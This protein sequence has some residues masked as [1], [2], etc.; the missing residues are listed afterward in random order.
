MSSTDRYPLGIMAFFMKVVASRTVSDTGRVLGAWCS[1]ACALAT[2]SSPA[3]SKG[4]T[5][6]TLTF[7]RED[8]VYEKL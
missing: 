5:P 7:G 2:T 4:P 1:C 8:D 6:E 3:F